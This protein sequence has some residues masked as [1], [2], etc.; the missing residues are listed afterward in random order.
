MDLVLKGRG[1]R[2]TDA[3][4]DTAEHKLGKLARVEPRATR[5]ELELISEDH[6][7]L[8]GTKTVEASLTLPRHTFRASASS[9]EVESALDQVVQ[10]LERQVKDRRGRIRRRVVAG[11]NRLKSSR[12]GS[13]APGSTA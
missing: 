9:R 6:P 1:V 10:R 3:L 13:E 12:F 4:R 11:A 7:R 5:V 8:D 2:I